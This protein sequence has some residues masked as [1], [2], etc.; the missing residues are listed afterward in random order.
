M[1]AFFRGQALGEN[2]LFITFDADSGQPQNAAE[3]SYALYDLTTGAEQLL[4]A[5]NRVPANPSVGHYYAS[6]LLPLDANIGKYHIK[7]TWRE[8]VGGPVVTGLFPFEIIDK[9][10]PITSQFT[11]CQQQ[12][13]HSMRVMLRDNNPDRNYRFRPP[14]HEETVGQFNR[15][16]GHIW[17]DEELAEY[18]MA[19]LNRISSAP[20]ETPFGSIE[21]LLSSRY[22]WRALLINGAMMD[23]L[24]AVSTNAAAESFDYS[25][26]G[27]SLSIDQFS[28]YES[29]HSAMRDRFE[30]DLE[31]AKRTVKVVRGLQQPRYG[32]GV[33]SSFGPSLGKNILSPRK[34]LGI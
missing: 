11:E 16:F 29:L 13:I 21:Q 23:A 9:A 34:F 15:V 30:A 22:N 26:G 12:L 4:G 7:W 1:S 31:K 18:L 2:D 27:V 6:V 10:V 17:L 14:A 5:P 19:S 20:P 32:M 8:Y 24:F 3:I 33:R 28:R 25:I